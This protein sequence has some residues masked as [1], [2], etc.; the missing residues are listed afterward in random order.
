ML[1]HHVCKDIRTVRKAKAEDL[2]GFVFLSQLPD[3]TRRLLGRAS[4]VCHVVDALPRPLE[5]AC[6]AMLRNIAA[7]RNDGCFRQQST[8]EV[9]ELVLVATRAMEEEENRLVWRT[10]A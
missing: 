2:R 3:V 8:A 4:E 9:E 5:E 7:R 10:G 1:E 6:C